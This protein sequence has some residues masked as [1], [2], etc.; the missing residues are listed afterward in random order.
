MTLVSKKIFY[1]WFGGK[2]PAMVNMC[3]NNWREKMPDY[4]I[5]E[6]NEKS[7]YF[8]FKKAYQ[9]CAWFRT[10][11]DRKMWAFVADYARCKVLYDYGGIYLDTDITI[12]KNLSELPANGFCCAE[13]KEGL[14]NAAVVICKPKYALLRDLLHFYHNEIFDS[15]LYT[16]PAIMSYLITK[17]KYK[18]L[19]V[20][21]REYF[22]PYYPFEPYYE[23]FRP[24]CITPETYT[25][26]WWNASWVSEDNYAFLTTKHLKNVSQ[27]I[28]CRVRNTV[29]YKLFSFFPIYSKK[30]KNG[31]IYYS[32]F[33]IPLLKIR[34]MAD[35]ITTKYYVLGLPILQLRK[36]V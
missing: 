9:T 24:E 27:G 6:I 22:Y 26:H 5:I 7:P 12:C 14:I 30:A 32:W 19:N 18:N 2:K 36:R 20:Y 17:N 29:S 3:I 8:D 11:Y 23:D 28:N 21:P 31:K 35:E 25:I 33:G 34:K 16:I 10:V 15:P 4:E 13:E 1:V